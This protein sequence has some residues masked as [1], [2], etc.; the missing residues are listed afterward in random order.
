MYQH[1]FQKN[2]ESLNGLVNKV[3]QGKTPDF[4]QFNQDYTLVS[5]KKD[6]IPNVVCADC[7]VY[8]KDILI[9][10]HRAEPVKAF[11]D[12]VT[13][14]SKFAS[15]PKYYISTTNDN[16]VP[17][18]LQKMMIRENGKVKKVFE[19]QTSHLAFVVKPEEFINIMNSIK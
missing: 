12:K 16:A 10:Y 7:P 11:N 15:V 14:T 13:L 9:K 17:A 1:S 2:G 18:V 6:A 8:M 5:I 3:T 4:F 19:M